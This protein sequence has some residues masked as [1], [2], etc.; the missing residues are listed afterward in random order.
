MLNRKCKDYVVPPRP[1]Q[2][3]VLG[4]QVQSA[5]INN[6]LGMGIPATANDYRNPRYNGRTTRAKI[7]IVALLGFEENKACFRRKNLMDMFEAVMHYVENAG[8]DCVVQKIL[9]GGGDLAQNMSYSLEYDID[10]RAASSKIQKSD[11]RKG[12]LSAYVMG[13]R[14]QLRV[15]EKGEVQVRIVEELLDTYTR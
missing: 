15:L 5:T 8:F 4:S 2:G 1:I 9:S 10:A 6:F 12:I 7:R 14:F 13:L 3:D 11:K